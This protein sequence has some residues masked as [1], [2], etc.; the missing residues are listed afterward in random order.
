MTD[1]MLPEIEPWQMT[2]IDRRITDMLVADGYKVTETRRIIGGGPNNHLIVHDICY[3]RGH[4]E[5]VYL[6]TH[7]SSC[8]RQERKRPVRKPLYKRKA[9][10]AD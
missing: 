4:D 10:L 2:A 8:Q 5:R 6:T 3:Q 1:R 7:G 9:P